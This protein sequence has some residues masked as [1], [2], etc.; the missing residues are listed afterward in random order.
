[1]N[2]HLDYT[3][4]SSGLVDFLLISAATLTLVLSDDGTMFSDN[5][6]SV[7]FLE[8]FIHSFQISFESAHG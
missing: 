3:Y 1:M 4:S 6:L 8:N 2:F 5:M 7:L